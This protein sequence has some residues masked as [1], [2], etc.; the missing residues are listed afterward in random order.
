MVNLYLMTLSLLRIETTMLCKDCEYFKITCE[1]HKAEKLI[2][3]WGEARCTKHNL[4]VNFCSH[5]KFN[6][7][8]CVEKEDRLDNGRS[9]NNTGEN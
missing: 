5:G 4:V 2:L 6:W 9:E 8:S 1:P 7:L 3:D